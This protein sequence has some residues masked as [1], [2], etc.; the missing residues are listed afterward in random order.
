[1]K[2]IKCVNVN[3]KVMFPLNDID[4]E[5]IWICILIQSYTKER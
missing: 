5:L 3:I 2:H 1:M 4:N